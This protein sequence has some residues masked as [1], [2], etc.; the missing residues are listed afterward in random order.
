MIKTITKDRET[1]K[2]IKET[3]S[4]GPTPEWEKFFPMNVIEDFEKFMQEREK[5]SCDEK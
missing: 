4:E 2:V 3:F 5:L 1:G